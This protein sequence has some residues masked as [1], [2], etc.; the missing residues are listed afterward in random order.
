MAHHKH[1]HRRQHGGD[2]SPHPIAN[3]DSKDKGGDQA[4]P[5][6]ATIVSVVYV[7][8]APTFDGPIGGYTTMAPVGAPLQ[9]SAKSPPSR[10]AAS[11]SPAN[12]QSSVIAPPSTQPTVAQSE[13]PASTDPSTVLPSSAPSS[14]IAI[15][16][17]VP[18]SAASPTTSLTTPLQTSSSMLLASPSDIS[19][20]S[21]VTA[22]SAIASPSASPTK[23]S[24]TTS[25]AMTGG[26]KAGL[27]FGLLFGIGA[28]VALVLFCYRRKKKQNKSYEKTDD[29]K[30]A[31]N[32]NSITFGAA[33]PPSTGTTRTSATAPRLSLRPVTQFYP[34]LGERR[35]S[36]NLLAS[37]LAA[38]GASGPTFNTTAA[39]LPSSSEPQGGRSPSSPSSSSN[40]FGDHAERP[41]PALQAMGPPL[42]AQTATAGSVKT[43]YPTDLAVAG[44]AVAAGVMAS[45]QRGPK[46]QYINP[47]LPTTTA[48][49]PSPTRTESSINSGTPDSAAA[50]APGSSNV[51]RVQLDFRPSM[52]DELELRAGQLVRLLHEYDDGWV[53][54]LS[55]S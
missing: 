2:D 49:L 5:K 6:V 35:K 8:A 31:F 40:P 52:E 28:V 48:P 3:R 53:I 4:S 16:S 22:A 26:A 11:P 42:A 9:A 39:E 23:A 51:H 55:L 20:S 17:T 47:N 46:P 29:E 45:H 34:D 7:T 12:A 43:P 30:S 15:Q 41:A 33:R 14:S 1:L 25:G 32:S 13:N 21:S 10:P 44:G 36:G 37:T 19:S 18:S 54:C 24:D 38:S 27:A 50:V